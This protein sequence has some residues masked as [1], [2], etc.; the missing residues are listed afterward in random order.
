MYN[1]REFFIR[2]A[3]ILFVTIFGF[4]SYSRSVG[5]SNVAT[6]YSG[7]QVSISTSTHSTKGMRNY[8]E[9]E[10]FVSGDGTFAAVFDGHGGNAVSRYARQT[11]YSCF[12][13][14]LPESRPWKDRS[15]T[16]AIAGAVYKV[17]SEVS[18]NLRWRHQGSTLAAVH[19]NAEQASQGDSHG[20]KQVVQQMSLKIVSA[21]V[22]DSR[23]VLGKRDK[24]IDLTKDHKPNSHTERARI[25][26]LGGFVQWHGIVKNKRPVKGAGV[27]RVNGNL[28]L[29]RAIGDAAERPCVSCDPDIR[30]TVLNLQRRGHSSISTAKSADSEYAEARQKST[31][32]NGDR[33]AADAN[34]R[35]A[36]CP[37]IILATDGLWD[38]FSSQ[39]AVSFV[40]GVLRA[41]K[42]Q[43]L[44]QG[45]I[46]SSALAPSETSEVSDTRR[47][48][49]SDVRIQEKDRGNPSRETSSPSHIESV[50]QEY[51]E[52]LMKDAEVV[53]AMSASANLLSRT[54]TGTV[55]SS[56]TATVW[57]AVKK[58][59]AK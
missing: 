19:V 30:L 56:S 17:D 28:A 49:G 43:L 8:M 42:E 27:Y 38:V 9:D 5:I 59:M 24:A 52:F 7:P 55:Q 51:A 21:N 37:F 47:M 35:N 11:L 45:Q 32:R 18:S 26:K 12:L 10:C 44:R 50:E 46:S 22:G 53:R 36:E 33:E 13:K 1:K 57:A 41:V 29:S 15:V 54:S 48:K 25:E 2:S 4:P 39:E 58:K 3:V 14:L 23:A 20:R 40:R 31:K 6:T 34:E 16:E